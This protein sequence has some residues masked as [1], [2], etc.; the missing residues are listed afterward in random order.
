MII[1]NHLYQ[2]IN[3]LIKVNLEKFN[4]NK[5]FYNLVV[6]QIYYILIII[7]INWNFSSCIYR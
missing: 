6:Y 1:I 3:K 7:I 5:I 4:L 2:S